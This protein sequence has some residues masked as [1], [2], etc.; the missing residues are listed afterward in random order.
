[1]KDGFVVIAGGLAGFGREKRAEEAGF[2]L[3]I[4]E[5]GVY[6]LDLCPGISGQPG[7]RLF[8]LR[9]RPLSP[10]V[11]G[12]FSAA[13]PLVLRP[14]Y[15]DDVIRGGVSLKDLRGTLPKS[16]RATPVIAALDS[17]GLAAFITVSAGE[18]AILGY[19]GLSEPEHSPPS[20]GVVPETGD[21][22]FFSIGGIDAQ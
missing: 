22:F 13:L 12:G 17:Q 15:S 11:E 9:V 3:L 19:R 8:T 18:T 6:K 16:R 7:E 14:V 1:V 20:V 10:L 2:S 4:K 5:P 21:F